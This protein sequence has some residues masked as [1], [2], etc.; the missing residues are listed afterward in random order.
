MPLGCF[1]FFR[2]TRFVYAFYKCIHDLC[3]LAVIFIRVPLA[4]VVKCFMQ[5]MPVFDAQQPEGFG[6]SVFVFFPCG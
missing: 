4:H 1:F 5:S 3:L 2:F 6:Q